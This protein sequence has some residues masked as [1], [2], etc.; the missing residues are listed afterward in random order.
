[1]KDKVN[2]MTSLRV[3]T[4]LGP[5]IGKATLLHFQTAAAD[6]Q[7]WNKILAL[8]KSREKILSTTLNERKSKFVDY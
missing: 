6:T 1:M 4:N 7:K 2:R 8:S 3:N 5:G